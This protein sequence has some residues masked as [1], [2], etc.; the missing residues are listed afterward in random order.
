MRINPLE[1]LKPNIPIRRLVLELSVPCP[2]DQ[3]DSIIKKGEI[4][5]HIKA[6]LYTLLECPN[7]ND[8]NGHS[9]SCGKILRRDLEHHKT[10]V[11]PYR[12]VECL[13]KCGLMLPLNYMEEHI[14]HECPKTII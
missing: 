3:C 8:P 12:I 5:K 6:C 14:S 7:N 4:E 10:E 9:G 13:L 11:C 1:G 2:N